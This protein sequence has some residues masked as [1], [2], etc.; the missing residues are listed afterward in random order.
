MFLHSSSKNLP[1]LFMCPLLNFPVFSGKSFQLCPTFALKSPPIIRASL[2]G[3][4][5]IIFS[6]FSYSS[7]RMCG[8][9]SHCF[10]V[11]AYT[12]MK[13]QFV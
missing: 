1:E 2:S 3:V 13:Y 7:S 5:F 4:L 12:D 9:V 10:S 11:G 8:S 6:I